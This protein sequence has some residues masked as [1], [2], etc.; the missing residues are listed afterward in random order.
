MEGKPDFLFVAATPTE[1]ASEKNRILTDDDGSYLCLYHVSTVQS[2]PV[3]CVKHINAVLL[4]HLSHQVAQANEG[5]SP[6]H[7]STVQM[8]NC[9]NELTQQNQSDT[10]PTKKKRDMMGK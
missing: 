3:H 9:I 1:G 6:P 10:S 8:Q 2:H 4:T 7:T 5:A